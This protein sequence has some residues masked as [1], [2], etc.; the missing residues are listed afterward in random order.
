M[1][2]EDIKHQLVIIIII[3]HKGLEE[4]KGEHLDSDGRGEGQEMA[5]LIHSSRCAGLI[6]NKNKKRGGGGR[7]QRKERKKTKKER[8]KMGLD[9]AVNRCDK[10]Y[11]SILA[12]TRSN[13]T[14]L[15]CENKQT[16]FDPPAHPHPPT[17]HTPPPPTPPGS[18]STS[19]TFS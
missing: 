3:V 13:Q 10:K 2:S 17:P 18:P 5:K 1:T 11:F 12:P 4:G 19:F 8:R 15:L 9:A 14:V 6:K 16:S 7:G